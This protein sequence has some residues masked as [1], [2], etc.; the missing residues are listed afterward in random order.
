VSVTVQNALGA[1]VKTVDTFAENETVRVNVKDLPHGTYRA[2]VCTVTGNW[3]LPFV[4][5]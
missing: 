5:R 2:Q 1:T 3:S 4:I